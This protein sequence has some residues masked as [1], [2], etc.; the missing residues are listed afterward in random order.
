MLND[1][2]NKLGDKNKKDVFDKLKNG[3][4]KKN[5]NIADAGNNLEKLLNKKQKENKFIWYLEK[6]AGMSEGFRILDKLF[7]DED[8]KN[9][10]DNLKK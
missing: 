6:K 7:K 5:K 1:I 10:R 9:F 4:L 8:K 2:K 3:E